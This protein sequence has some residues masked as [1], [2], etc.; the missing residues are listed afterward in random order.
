MRYVRT[1]T[2]AHTHTHTRQCHM[3]IHACDPTPRAK[4]RG[5]RRPGP[6]PGLSEEHA[7]EE[8]RVGGD[9]RRRA[10][11]GARGP[12]PGAGAPAP[13]RPLAVASRGKGLGSRNPRFGLRIVR[14]CLGET[15]PCPH[16]CICVWDSARNHWLEPIPDMVDSNF[17]E[18]RSGV[19][20]ASLIDAKAQ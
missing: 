20:H 1:R 18:R 8:Q 7:S 3:H 5:S 12:A 11:P 16:P 6:A 10:R 14:T 4:T 19:G 2:H 15:T 9:E 17:S 13:G